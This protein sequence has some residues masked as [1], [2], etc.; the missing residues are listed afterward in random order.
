MHILKVIAKGQN[1][2]TAR[3]VAVLN[4]P[5]QALQSTLPSTLSLSAAA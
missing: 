5:P 4:R 3:S 2:S 1:V